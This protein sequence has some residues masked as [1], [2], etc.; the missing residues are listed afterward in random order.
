LVAR[1]A[2]YKNTKNKKGS[3]GSNPLR[4]YEPVVLVAPLAQSLIISS[5]P[6][7]EL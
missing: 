3:L 5:T 1:S 6:F 2:K 4:T 7:V